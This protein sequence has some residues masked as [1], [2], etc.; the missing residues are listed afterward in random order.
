M[1]IPKG[2]ATTIPLLLHHLGGLQGFEINVLGFEGPAPRRAHAGILVDM[3][4]SSTLI[5]H[6]GKQ[7]GGLLL[8]DVWAV[9][10]DSE[11][12]QWELRYS[13]KDPDEEEEEEGEEED[14][15][16]SKKKHKKRKKKKRKG[17]VGPLARKGHLA[18]AVPGT[19]GPKM[20][21]ALASLQ[22]L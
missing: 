11:E 9:P 22:A 20:V 18:V 13:P 3:N 6:G 12:A 21:R 10:L 1:L 2:L 8:S 7:P 5:I 14:E 16:L 4:S 15:G 19:E 17:H